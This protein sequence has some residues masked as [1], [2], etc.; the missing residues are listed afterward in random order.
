MTEAEWK[1][2]RDSGDRMVGVVVAFGF[3]LFV[4]LLGLALAINTF[5]PNALKKQRGAALPPTQVT[6]ADMPPFT[7]SFTDVATEAG[8][9]HVQASGAQGERLL[10]E[11]MGSGVALGDL[12]GDGDPDL[13]LLSY[14]T[15]PALYRNDSERG[16]E[17]RFTNVTESSGLGDLKSTTTA[18]FGDIDR[19]GQLDVLIGR[20]GSDV[21]MRNDGD[22]RFEPIAELGDGWTSAAGFV[23]VE[24]DGDTDLVVGSY[25]KWSPEIDRE[26]NYTLDGIGRAYGPP[27]G[28]EATDLALYINDGTGAFTDETAGRGLQIRRSDRD[29][30]VM[31][32]LGLRFEDVNRDK[33]I[34][35]LV[36]NDT[37]PNRLLINDGSGSFTDESVKYGIAYDMDGKSTGAMGIDYVTANHEVYCAIGNFA[38]EP[39]SLYKA[40]YHRREAAFADVSAVSGV[41][42]ATRNE[43]TFGTLFADVDLDGKPDLIQINGHIEPDI[44]RVQEGQTYK[45]RAQLFR[46]T[47]QDPP[48]LEVPAEQ[49]GDLAEAIVGR[50]AARADLDGD[51]DYDLVVSRIDGVPLIL[52]NNVDHTGKKVSS[53]RIV[54]REGAPFVDGVHV[55]LWGYAGVDSKQI[56]SPTMSYMS[57]SDTEILSGFSGQGGVRSL[58]LEFPNGMELRLHNPVRDDVVITEP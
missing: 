52:R 20:I 13:L 6:L 58:M 8:V 53:I 28:F 46:G 30:P 50:A 41:G 54:N 44:A 37:T 47:G 55:E 15:T 18:A 48:F 11:T 21:L 4:C 27:T 40:T 7:A 38:N 49:L 45:Q 22:L 56:L 3:A 14:G 51:G 26:V 16:G 9:D 1:G 23:D 57:Q 43:L 19:D 36:A 32:A 24:G 2:N 42:P 17:I 25:V 39:S 33:N 31:K 5:A 34:D 12:D 10:P 35:I 29:V